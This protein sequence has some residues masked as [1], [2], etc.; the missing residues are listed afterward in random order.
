MD[1]IPPNSNMFQSL[2]DQATTTDE[3]L[4]LIS[5]TFP[6]HE[7]NQEDHQV[8]PPTPSQ[9][10]PEPSL[11]GRRCRSSTSS[12]AAD[13]NPN[14][15]KKKMLHRDIEKQRRQE[16]SNLYASLRSLIPLQYLK[17]KRST[18]DQMH[19]ATKYIKDLEIKIEKMSAKRDSLKKLSDPSDI[20]ASHDQN[21][22]FEKLESTKIS[23]RH[24]GKTRSVEVLVNT[25][26]S[27]EGL[28][29]ERI[30]RALAAEGFD[31][32]SCVSAKVNQRFLHTIQSQAMSEERSLDLSKL[33]QKLNNLIV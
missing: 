19:E 2:F 24:C 6:K 25:A 7:I 13:E 11:A 23:L 16:M 9:K 22:N 30:L 4:Q 3:L 20:I 33:E 26:F 10:G 12:A 1:Y 5:S 27:S 32:I 15:K 31:V 17:G 18:S 8:P 29:L 14:D 21:N 28:S